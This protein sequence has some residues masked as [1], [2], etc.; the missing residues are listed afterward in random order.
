MVNITEWDARNH[1]PTRMVASRSLLIH[2][3]DLS[4]VFITE[5]RVDL[6]GTYGTGFERVVRTRYDFAADFGMFM[7]YSSVGGESPIRK[8]KQLPLLNTT[9]EGV[10][11]LS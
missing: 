2:G 7:A 11:V 9:T 3:L 1:R 10:N 4:G 6:S 5:Y 8:W